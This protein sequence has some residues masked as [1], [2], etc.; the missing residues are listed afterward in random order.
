[1]K[2]QPPVAGTLADDA[3]LVALAGHAGL[4]KCWQNWPDEVRDAAVLAA[5]Y[6]QLLA[7][8]PGAEIA[9]WS[10]PVTKEEL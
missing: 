6:T 8:D 9:P 7:E 5:T 1:M 3:T 2:E 4:M 10:F